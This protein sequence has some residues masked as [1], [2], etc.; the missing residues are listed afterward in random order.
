MMEVVGH[1][2]D[3]SEF[4]DFAAVHES[5]PGTSRRFAAMRSQVRY[6]GAADLTSQAVCSADL[7][8][9]GLRN[10]YISEGGAALIS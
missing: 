9:H 6:P 3:A 2:N 4:S 8:V 5:L 7:W 1:K 10:K